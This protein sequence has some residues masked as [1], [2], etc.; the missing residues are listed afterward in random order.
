MYPSYLEYFRE[1]DSSSLVDFDYDRN[2]FDFEQNSALPVLKG[3]LRSCLSYG[4]TIGANSFVIDTI[5]LGYRIPFISTPCQARFSNSQSALNDASFVE[6]AIAELAHTHAVVEVPFIP[7]VVNLLSVSIQSSGKKRL[8]LD[9]RHV[10]HFIWKQKFRCEDWRVLLSYVNKGDCL[11]SFDLKSGYHHIDIFPDQQTFLGFSWV[12]LF[13]YRSVF[14]FCI[15]SV[16]SELSPIRLHEV[17][18]TTR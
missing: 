17:S 3:R 10:N 14:L 1:R 15:T 5:K 12:F 4:H 6:L 9:L 11:F 16:R 13:W 2:L 18:Q 8:I 7:H